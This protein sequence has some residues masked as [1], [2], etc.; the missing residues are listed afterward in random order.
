MSFYQI[1]HYKY[2]LCHYS[3]AYR[4]MK[5]FLIPFLLLLFI[6]C[7]PNM[8]QSTYPLLSYFSNQDSFIV[9][10]ENFNQLKS[11]LENNSQFSNFIEKAGF[12]NSAQRFN[13]IKNIH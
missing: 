9:R 12:K 3:K 6:G 7:K 11:N 5:S 1:K 2:Y 4:P 10:T 13:L 8:T